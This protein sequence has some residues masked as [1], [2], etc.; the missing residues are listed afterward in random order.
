MNIAGDIF[1]K[2]EINPLVQISNMR[3][4]II[5]TKMFDLTLEDF[6]HFNIEKFLNLKVEWLNKLVY[7][8]HIEQID[9]L[10]E[11]VPDEIKTELLKMKELSSEFSQQKSVLAPMYYAKMLYYDEL[12]FRMIDKNEVLAQG[13]RYK[14]SELTSVGFAIYTDT[15]CEKLTK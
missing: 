1:K 11:I 7:L 3:I 2:L 4:P 8:Q 13:G 12:L 15:L 14:D 6:R 5:L 9:A 10:I